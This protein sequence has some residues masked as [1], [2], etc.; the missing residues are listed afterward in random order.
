MIA[1][2]SSPPRISRAA[3]WTMGF[4]WAGKT[5]STSALRSTRSL[6]AQQMSRRGSP[7][8]SRRWAVTRIVR[9]PVAGASILPA[10]SSKA[11]MTVLPV[12]K[13]PSLEIPSWRRFSTALEVGAKCRRVSWLATRRFISS[14]KGL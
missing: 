9:R 11:S 14:G 5:T 7:Q 13:I 10:V 2:R 4:R 3:F 6:T 8:F 1:T 12:R